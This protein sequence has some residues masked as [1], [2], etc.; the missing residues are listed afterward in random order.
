MDQMFPCQCQPPSVHSKK[1]I[2]KVHLLHRYNELSRYFP[3]MFQLFPT[4]YSVNSTWQSLMDQ[5]ESG[6]IVLLTMLLLSA[7][8]VYSTLTSTFFV[9]A[10]VELLQDYI[11]VGLWFEVTSQLDKQVLFQNIRS[12]FV[13]WYNKELSSCYLAILRYQVD[14]YLIS[15]WCLYLFDLILMSRS[16]KIKVK[17]SSKTWL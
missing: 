7:Y 17:K 10:K 3:G 13:S 9:F 4:H 8:L 15:I 14:V 1:Q 5:C 6:Q 16:W 2:K 12:I 11:W